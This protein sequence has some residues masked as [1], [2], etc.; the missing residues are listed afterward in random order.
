MADN[1]QQQAPGQ[2]RVPE[3]GPWDKALEQLGDLDP[4]WTNACL[5][6]DD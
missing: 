6:N 3:V 5:K 4:L 2:Q 1:N